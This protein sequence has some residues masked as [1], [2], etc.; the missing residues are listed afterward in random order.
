MERAETKKIPESPY[1]PAGSM[2]K[3]RGDKARGLGDSS[4]GEWLEMRDKSW[5]PSS[6]S[7]LAR[8]MLTHQGLQVP[9]HN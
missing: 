7:S 5:L 6:A 2:Q 3:R 4:A 9:D 8:A 1:K